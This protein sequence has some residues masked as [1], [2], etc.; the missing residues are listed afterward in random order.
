MSGNNDRAEHNSCPL[1]T[2]VERLKAE[3]AHLRET[4]KDR[5]SKETFDAMLK[6]QSEANGRLDERIATLELQSESRGKT[7]LAQAETIA[8][9]VDATMAAA[10]ALET[11][12]V[13]DAFAKLVAQGLREALKETR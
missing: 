1:L 10:F 2:E 5:V 6:E 3:N 13:S 11:T 9:L 7:A 12:T 4:A 8:K